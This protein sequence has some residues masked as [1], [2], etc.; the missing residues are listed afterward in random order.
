MVIRIG[1]HQLKIGGEVPGNKEAEIIV[2]EELDNQVDLV[3]EEE[4]L[5][6][7]REVEEK[8]AQD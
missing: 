3:D 5:A 6:D 1:P 7:I 8:A 4:E 2:V